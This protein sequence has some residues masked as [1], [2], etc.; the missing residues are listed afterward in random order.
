MLFPYISSSFK[1]KFYIHFWG[2]LLSKEFLLL[3]W[4]PYIPRS[5]KPKLQITFWGEFLSKEQ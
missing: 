1:L 5:F 2:E 3:L 4:F